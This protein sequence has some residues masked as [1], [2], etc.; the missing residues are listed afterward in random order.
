L[1]ESNA[2]AAKFGN[3]EDEVAAIRETKE[4]NDKQKADHNEDRDGK[5]S[6][7]EDKAKLRD[8]PVKKKR[9]SIIAKHSL[10]AD[11]YVF[12]KN[13]FKKVEIQC[14]RNTLSLMHGL[15]NI[16]RY[17][18]DKKE[19]NL[20][21]EKKGR[22]ENGTNNHTGSEQ[23]RVYKRSQSRS[24]SPPA[25]FRR[26]NHSYSLSSARLMQ[27]IFNNIHIN[28]FSVTP[29]GYRRRFLFGPEHHLSAA[30]VHRFLRASAPEAALPGFPTT[31]GRTFRPRAI[32]SGAEVE[33]VHGP[34]MNQETAVHFPHLAEEDYAASEETEPR[35][36]GPLSEAMV[37]VIFFC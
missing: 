22:H 30:D 1:T 23:K 14:I 29:I 18:N 37:S 11:E 19:L 26:Q 2:H 31:V 5:Q 28:S 36:G 6:K 17:F 7:E 15:N 34:G 35:D 4:M 13:T 3:E 27:L 9:P 32:C 12:P 25:A 8:D 33:A 24:P 20:P 21:R 16:Y 10:V